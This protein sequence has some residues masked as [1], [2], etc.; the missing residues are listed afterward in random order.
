MRASTLYLL[1]TIFM[2]LV[3]CAPPLVNVEPVKSPYDSL[4][5]LAKQ[6]AAST[7]DRP[8]AAKAG[9]NRNFRYGCFCGA[10]HPNIE[11]P[12]ALPITSWNDAQRSTYINRYYRIL[13]IDDIDAACQTHDV[14]WITQ[15][16]PDLKCNEQ[17]VGELENLEYRFASGRSWGTKPDWRE[18]CE[19]LAR[20]VGAATFMVMDYS[21]ANKT[22]NH[23]SLGLTRIL[24]API[25]G[26]YAGAVTLLSL[27]PDIYPSEQERCLVS[28]L[29]TLER[30]G[31]P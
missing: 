4:I 1:P 12:S 18:R 22:N 5:S 31:Q 29:K 25:I 8:V 24:G 10:N 26:F 13:P 23:L 2:S 16:R 7:C 19:T 14:C 15:D 30:A 11:R 20:D 6:Q 28:L 21:W 17:L 27:D 3:A 9:L